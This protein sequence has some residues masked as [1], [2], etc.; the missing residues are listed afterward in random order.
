MKEKKKINFVHVEDTIEVINLAIDTKTNL[1]LYGKGGYGKTELVKRVLQDRGLTYSTVVGNKD[2]SL[3]SLIGVTD[4]KKFIDE[5]ELKVAFEKS[6]FMGA[7]VLLLEEFLDVPEEIASALK[8]VI[9]EGGLRTKTDFIEADIK[10]VI[11]CTNKAPED[12]SY[13]DSIKAFYMERF[14]LHHKVEWKNNPRVYYY[15]L[16]KGN[17]DLDEKALNVI[18]YICSKTE[19]SPRIALEAAKIYKLTGSFEKLK[20]VNGLKDVDIIGL[21]A[22]IER[23]ETIKSFTEFLTKINVLVDKY[24]DNIGALL[25]IKG[26]LL[27]NDYESIPERMMAFST[28]RISVT[29]KI[30]N[31]KIK[32]TNDTDFIIKEEIDE[33]FRNTKDFAA[34]KL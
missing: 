2:T 18:S 33:A 34:Q 21:S 1:V 25:L 20:F 22:E 5:S 14:P 28:L 12:V 10:Q 26:K 30:S 24:R 17:T 29:N 31:L 23:K 7:D 16:L 9:S 8:D 3:E 4:V 15:D 6:P 13:N 19:V 27:D 11:I 32:L